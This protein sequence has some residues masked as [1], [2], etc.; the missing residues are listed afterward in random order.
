MPLFRVK[1]LKRVCNSTGYETNI[2]QRVFD[3]HATDQE[4]AVGHAKSRFTDAEATGQWWLRA[5]RIETEPV[6]KKDSDRA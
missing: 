5:D 4:E 6:R 3:I 2:C 1:F